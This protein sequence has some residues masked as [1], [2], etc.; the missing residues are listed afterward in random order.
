MDIGTKVRTLYEHSA[1]GVVVR[2]RKSEGTPSADWF[3]VRF[4]DDG[5]RLCIHREMLAIS[6][7]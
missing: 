3:I 2:P 7:G 1:T 5:G 6:N 4:D